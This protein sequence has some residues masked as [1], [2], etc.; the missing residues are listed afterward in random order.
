MTFRIRHKCGCTVIRRPVDDG[1]LLRIVR[2][3]TGC[4]RIVYG[5]ECVLEAL[6]AD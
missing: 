5:A 4:A 2:W 3:C 6:R 1:V